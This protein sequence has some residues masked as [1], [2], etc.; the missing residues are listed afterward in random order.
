VYASNTNYIVRSSLSS[1]T[2]TTIAATT[3][4]DGYTLYCCTTDLCNGTQMKSAS[5]ML[6]MLVAAL[7]FFFKM[8]SASQACKR[9]LKTSYISLIRSFLHIVF[10]IS[11][12]NLN[13]LCSV[14]NLKSFWKIFMKN[15]FIDEK[16]WTLCEQGIRWLSCSFYSFV[17]WF[18]LNNV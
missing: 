5:V 16:L 8:W 1:C 7:T 10:F 3:G 4:N 12:I 2:A 18:L 17:D 9:Q 6:A 14:Q 15:Y 11:P 13:Y